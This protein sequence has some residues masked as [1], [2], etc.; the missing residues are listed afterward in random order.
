MRGDIDLV[1]VASTR[2]A[3]CIRRP[4]GNSFFLQQLLQAH[5]GQLPTLPADTPR[6]QAE[7]LVYQALEAHGGKRVK[8]ARQALAIDEDC[9]EAYIIL[10][11]ETARD[12]PEA[13]DLFL[14][15]MA[16][17]E[18][19]LGGAVFLRSAPATLPDGAEVS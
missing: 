19:T 5:G 7:D 6:Q 10:A 16:A 18:R 13:R 1:K 11:E 15:A 8:L 2:C 3:K 9:A 4:P 14:K 12:L 17:A